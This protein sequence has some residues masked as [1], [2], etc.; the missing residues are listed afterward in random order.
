VGK[1]M[2]EIIIMA[3]FDLPK[4]VAFRKTKEKWG[5]LSNM[6]A[7]YPITL[8][9]TLIRTSEALYQALKFTDHP[10]I[11]QKI[12]DEKSPM[13]AKM[14][15]KKHK[16]KIHPLWLWGNVEVMYLCIQAKA[17]CNLS[18]VHLLCD[19]GDTQIVEVSHK[20]GFWGAVPDKDNPN[21]AYGMNK[22]GE[23]LMCWR[24]EQNNS[25]PQASQ[26]LIF[27][28]PYPAYGGDCTGVVRFKLL[29][30]D[31][32]DLHSKFM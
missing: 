25:F 23:L 10:D 5:G 15:A 30:A 28:S 11:Q 3:K 24:G 13:A 27:R 8:N 2:I 21:I 31:I 17:Y 19:T 6:A 12:I 29:G 32:E 14:V 22:L 1:E 20:D 26:P 4:C 7:G 16:D 9:G 18:F